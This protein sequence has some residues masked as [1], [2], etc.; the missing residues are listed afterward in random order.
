VE[1]VL[2]DMLRMVLHGRADEVP[3]RMRKIV[4]TT[5]GRRRVKL[6]EPTRAAIALLLAEESSQ[7]GAIRG[8]GTRQRASSTRGAPTNQNV[9]AASIDSGAAPPVLEARDRSALDDVMREYRERE[10]LEVSGL[11]PTRTV[12]LSGPPGTGKS[13]T[14]AFLADQIGYPLIRIEPADVIGSFLGE[15]ARLLSTVFEQARNEGAI[16]ALDEIDALAKRRD[17]LHDVGEFKRFVTTLLM[18]LDR[19]PADAPLI[20]ATNHLDLLDP[21]L[22]RRFEMHL[23]LGPPG[24]EER[25]TILEQ[26]LG[27]LGT[28]VD[29]GIVDTLVTV[30]DGATGADLNGLVQR[31]ARRHVLDSEP[32]ER[33]LLVA[34]L[35]GFP[36]ALD[37]DARAKFATAAHDRGGLS[38]RKIGDLLG[39]SHTAVGRLVKVG[40]S[41]PETATATA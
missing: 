41:V 18:E 38:T 27:R 3:S 23:R 1:A 13:M 4:S 6:S 20:A 33:A 36:Q 40:S 24:V 10:R 9:R 19:W 28:P 30:L 25:R 5:A 39:C 26:S 37:R 17:D 7:A 15:S 16:L 21:A 35:R 34:A 31:A 14:I 22:E 32:L 12:L 11:H 2:V 29:S 8:S